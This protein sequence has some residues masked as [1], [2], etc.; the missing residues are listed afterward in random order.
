MQEERKGILD[1]EILPR[2]K[3]LFKDMQL[4]ES[5]VVQDRKEQQ[6]FKR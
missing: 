6:A 5:Q 3:D 2:S 1:P 4:K